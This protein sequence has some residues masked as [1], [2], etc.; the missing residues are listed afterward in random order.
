MN[1]QIDNYVCRGYLYVYTQSAY[2]ST[3][4]TIRFEK[5]C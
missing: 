4:K 2:K 1:M 5:K 3:E